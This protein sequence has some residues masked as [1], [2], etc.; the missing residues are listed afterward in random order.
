[1]RAFFALGAIISISTGDY[2]LD[3]YAAHQDSVD[4]AYYAWSDKDW[5]S[6]S[7]NSVSSSD[8][9]GCA[10]GGYFA[11]S[12]GEILHNEIMVGTTC[13]WFDFL[14]MRDYVDS[15]A[16][17]EQAGGSM[18]SIHTQ[19]EHDAVIDLVPGHSWKAAYI[20]AV[21]DGSGNF[22]WDDGTSWDFEDSQRETDGLG[23]GTDEKNVAIKNRKWADYGNGENKLGVLCRK[24]IGG[25]IDFKMH[26]DSEHPVEAERETEALSDSIKQGVQ[27]AL[28]S[29]RDDI[30]WVHVGSVKTARRLR[31]GPEFGSEVHIELG[32]KTRQ[33][34]SAAAHTIKQPAFAAAVQHTFYGVM[35]FFSVATDVDTVTVQY[36]PASV[37][38][39]V[40][41]RTEATHAQGASA[42]NTKQAHAAGVSLN[43]K[44]TVAQRLVADGEST[45]PAGGFA[46]WLVAAALCGAGLA[47]LGWRSYYNQPQTA[48]KYEQQV[49]SKR[50]ELTFNPASL[51]G[52]KEC[53]EI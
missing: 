37:T 47:S 41:A 16:Y 21:S 15:K 52:R 53:D 14:Q 32:F 13:F 4:Y 6:K 24:E 42:T 26:M 43:S 48:G 1:M 51:G 10:G 45:G 9:D 19:D 22:E 25:R 20:G 31:S 40:L 23:W 3:Y 49:C 12:D 5:E 28:D 39:D 29:L 34:V 46:I 11:A 36:A 18:A 30:A 2:N 33:G 35:S 50:T 8:G 7:E 27:Y 38:T 17:C 44:A